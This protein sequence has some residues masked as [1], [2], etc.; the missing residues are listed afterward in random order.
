MESPTVS[1]VMPAY[2]VE[3]YIAHAIECV[4]QQ[5]L[6]DWELIVV[7]DATPD[8]SAAI[9]ERFAQADPR[10]T[11]IHHSENQGLSAARNTGMKQAHGRYLWFADPDDTYDPT[12]LEQSVAVLDEHEA[13]VA[14]FGVREAYY[15]ADG[16]F[17]Y[18]HVVQPEPGI[19]PTPEAVHS[20]LLKLE[21]E[22]CYGYAWNKV[23]RRSFLDTASLSFENVKL[24]EDITFN[25][26]VFN[27]VQSMVI[28][29]CAP[30]QYARRIE[31][32]LTNKFLPDYFDLHERRIQMLVDQQRNWGLLDKEAKAVLGGLYARYVLSAAER[33]CDPRAHMNRGD[34]ISWLC[35]VFESKL[36]N[37]LIPYAQAAQS[38]ALAQ[39]LKPLKAKDANATVRLAH[40]IHMTRT[41]FLPLF[42]KIKSR[43]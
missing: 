37:E 36:F 35:T 1:I 5:T 7:D 8:K 21:Q 16:S 2:G 31:D 24:I 28:L 38:K 18:D 9:A 25:V 27:H 17:S 34:Q 19:Y 12:L 32:N 29:D 11:V 26:K 3:A 40:I 14:V 33:N 22:T 4:Q 42:T 13:D 39:A 43:R 15:K 30:Y 23:Y 20:R 6:K 10:I 41:H